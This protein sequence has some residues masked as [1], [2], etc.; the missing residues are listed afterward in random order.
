M[1]S[2]V[3]SAHLFCYKACK[4]KHCDEHNFL[5]LQHTYQMTSAGQR[6]LHVS[7]SK[8]PAVNAIQSSSAGHAPLSCSHVLRHP[9][10]RRVSIIMHYKQLRSEPV[11][12]D[13]EYA[14][15]HACIVPTELMSTI[16]S[17]AGR[18]GRKYSAAY[19]L[20]APWQVYVHRLHNCTILSIRRTR[21]C[22]GMQ[23]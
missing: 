13:V 14:C 18:T 21:P 6:S 20:I 12:A 8:K 9:Q 17:S 1:L 16:Y 4:I 7:P 11:R 3:E 10:C 22:A 5:C 19:R 15:M 2:F 23:R